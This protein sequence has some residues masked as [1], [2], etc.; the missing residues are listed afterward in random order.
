[1]TQTPQMPI[2]Q[3]AWS[4]MFPDVE[5]LSYAA[6]WFVCSY[7]GVT[8]VTHGGN[9][10]GM[11][12][13]AAVVPDKGFGIVAF[14]NVNGCRLPQALV[15]QSI[16]NL[17]FDLSTKQLDEFCARERFNR[18][19]L[20]FAETDRK[21]CTIPEHDAVTFA[22]GIRGNLR[23]CVLRHGER[24]AA[25]RQ[26]ASKLHRLRRA[27]RSLAVR[28]LHHCDRRPVPSGVQ[29]DRGLR[30]RR[31]RRT[32]AAHARRAGRAAPEACAQTSGPAGRRRAA[33]R[34][35]A[36]TKAASNRR[37]PR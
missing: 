30:A 23:R 8:V 22:R 27:A 13:V 35:C 2:A 15:F 1:M 14:A 21:R 11:S 28:Q 9:V 25:R 18:E 10:D 7:R 12:A 20:D 16:D 5:F 4:D 32:V 3:S 31:F 37:S 29:V 33:S 6:G 26:A 24:D 17:I 19:R 36:G 34:S